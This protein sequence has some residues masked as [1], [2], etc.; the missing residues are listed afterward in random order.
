MKTVMKPGLQAPKKKTPEVHVIQG[1]ESVS[2]TPGQVL[3]KK[4]QP[5][6]D[7]LF[8]ESGTVE[9]FNDRD[10]AIITL[11]EMKAG[12]VIGVMTCLNNGPRMASARAKT[13]VICKQIPHEQILKA[14][15][16]LPTW[17]HIVLKEFSLRLNHSN[18]QFS[19][20]VI[21]AKKLESNALNSV[22]TATQIAATLSAAGDSFAKFLDDRRVIYLDDIQERITAM[23]NRPADEI[24][25]ILSALQESGVLFVEVG[26]EKKRHFISLENAKKLT[27]FLHFL[28]E[29]KTGM[30][31]K[32]LRAKFTNREFRVAMA[33][34]KYTKKLNLDSSKSVQIPIMEIS[35]NLEKITT[36]PFDVD[37]MRQISDLGLLTTE[38]S[39]DD[40]K[41][42]FI[43]QELSRTMTF[44]EAL[45]R[46]M[47]MDGPMNRE[48][49]GGASTAA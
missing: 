44:V 14:V 22:F 18:E 21:R 27:E 26:A 38:G 12:E 7:L 28:Q 49:E 36:T 40:I 48:T 23:L 16:E 3:F 17:F 39:G 15:N 6:G 34:V 47:I 35:Q 10:G 45:R 8:I 2:F 42:I 5:G 24:R 11:S 31:K 19:D 37:A 29:T 4:G 33:M 32:L 25:G 30:K 13:T 20:A 1:A 43:P 41:L 9:I 46:L